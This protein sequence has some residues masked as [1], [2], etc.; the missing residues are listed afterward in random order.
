MPDDIALLERRTQAEA[1]E[2][3]RLLRGCRRNSAATG[4]RRG[5]RRLFR[6]VRRRQGGAARRGDARHL[7]ILPGARRDH[8][9]ADHL[10]RVQHRRGRGGLARC[11]AHRPLCPPSG[12]G[13]FGPPGVR[14]FPDLDVAQRG[15]AGFSRLAAAPQR[16]PAGRAADRRSAVS[17]C[18]ASARRS[19]RCSPISTRSI[20]TPPPARAG[21]TA[22]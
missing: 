11:G 10:A 16:E 3:A 14:A 2:L 22:A 4:T 13:D 6:Q 18:T 5:V 9:T 15:G 1:E 8:E 21:A 7:R 12:A 17:T 19:R 20:R